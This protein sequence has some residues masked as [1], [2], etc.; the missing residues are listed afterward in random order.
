MFLDYRIAALTFEARMT[1]LFRSMATVE[2]TLNTNM[3][4][5]KNMGMNIIKNLRIQN[6]EK[7]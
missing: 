5:S 4:I 3:K 7:R 1:M 6:L 2:E